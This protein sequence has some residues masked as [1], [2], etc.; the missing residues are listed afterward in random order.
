MEINEIKQ[1][2]QV[3]YVKLHF[4][5]RLLEDTILPKNKVSALRGGMGQMLL[6]MNCVRN[7]ECDSCDFE[8]ECIVRR[9]MYSKLSQKPEYM[10]QGDSLGYVFECD[11]LE[12]YFYAGDEIQFNLILFGKNIV[13]FHQYL[14]AFS[15]LGMEGLGKNSSKFVVS[16]VYNTRN[17]IIFENNNVYMENYH[18]QTVWEYVE[19]RMKMQ[20]TENT[21]VFASPLTVK[22]QGEFIR[23]FEIE[24]IVAAAIRRIHMLN[25]FEN[26]NLE[27][28]KKM[29]RLPECT[30][31]NVIDTYVDRYSATHDNK[32]RLRGI[33]GS[34][35][36]NE[37]DLELKMLLLAGELIHIGKN[38]SFGFGKYTLVE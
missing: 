31:L 17:K 37:M 11:N 15:Y 12:E 5:L 14:Q 28:L 25:C 13:Y 6:K 7:H 23:K 32:I 38:T 29:D 3:R 27:P 8:D 35:H 22:Y 24:A 33:R 30:N 19:Y 4:T 34:M 16:S 1:A 18:I 10:K 9:M 20:K 2:L 26:L 36:V 21:I